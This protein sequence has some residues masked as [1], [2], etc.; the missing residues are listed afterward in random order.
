VPESFISEWPGAVF[1]SEPEVELEPVVALFPVPVACAIATVDE[2]AMARAVR[3]AVKIFFV[4]A[5][6]SCSV[7]AVPKTRFREDLVISSLVL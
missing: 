1:I 4:K 5:S 6:L 7:P 3:P 2:A